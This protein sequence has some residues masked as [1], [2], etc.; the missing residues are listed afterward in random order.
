MSDQN[1][2]DKIKYKSRIRNSVTIFI[3]IFLFFFGVYTGTHS[4]LGKKIITRFP[5]LQYSSAQ[6][7]TPAPISESEMSQFWYIW[8][9]LEQKYP[10]KETVPKN[11]EK[12]YGAIS[13]LVASYKDPYTMFFPP[14]QAK[15]F[16]QEV[17]G[18]FGGIGI[19]FGVRGG[20]PT[21]IAPLKK[22]PAY[23]AG[24]KPGDIIISV[25][26]KKVEE[27]DID[28]ITSWIRGNEGSKVT[29]S[30]LRKGN[31]DPLRFEIT[32]SKIN[33]PVIDTEIKNDVFI[34]HFYTFSEKSATLFDEAIN[35]FNASGKQ[36]LL[37]DMRSNPG[38]YLDAAV[39]I[40]S[41]ILPMSEVIVREDNGTGNDPYIYR[42]RGYK[43]IPNNVK[44][45]VLLDEGSAS[46]SEILAG[47]LQDHKRATLYGAKSFG[48]GSVQELIQLSDGSSIKITIAKW[49]TPNGHSISEKGIT[50]DVIIDTEKIIKNNKNKI[51]DPVLDQVITAMSRK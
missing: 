9:L 18:E 2:N 49:F 20:M 7:N 31:K 29:L 38:G 4:D 11:Q 23:I 25:D 16:N 50:P 32:R 40:A 12:M 47:A 51:I 37:I 21:V 42:S 46:A 13:G 30:V 41:N 3:G 48:K 45:G 43:K 44:I 14:T 22:S 17:K 8:S 35:S 24:I 6:A 33:I 28:K 1:I 10:F 26:D 39:E 15:L 27:N 36:K 34:I 19:E 5:F